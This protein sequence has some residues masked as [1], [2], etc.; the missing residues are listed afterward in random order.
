VFILICTNLCVVVW[1]K[2]IENTNNPFKQQFLV[3][4]N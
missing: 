1:Q 2:N 3:H 4:F